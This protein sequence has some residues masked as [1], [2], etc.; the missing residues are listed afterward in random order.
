GDFAVVEYLSAEAAGSSTDVLSLDRC[1]PLTAKSAGLK[2]DSFKRDTIDVPDDLREYS[3]RPDAYTEYAK[4][5]KNLF[6]QYDAAAGKLNLMSCYSQSIKRA[7]ILADMYFK[8]TRQKI[9]LLQ[10]Q[11]EAQKQ[12]QVPGR[13][14]NTH[15]S[16]KHVEEFTVPYDLMGLAIGSHGANIQNARA[17]S[18][19]EDIQLVESDGTSPCLFKVYADSVDAAEKAR[20]LLEYSIDSCSVPRN[21]VGKVIG[22]A[23]KTIQEIVDKSGVVRVQIE[24]GDGDQRDE[25]SVDPVPF[26]F[27]GTRDAISNASFLIDFHLKHLKE[28]EEMRSNVDELNRQLYS[29]RTG[30]PPL[31]NG[32]FQARYDRGGGGYNADSGFKSGFRGGRGGPRGAF[33]GGRGGYRGNPRNG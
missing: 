29:C 9:M 5:V 28:M 18:G 12:L 4:A 32:S 26:V 20:S 6:V 22:K 8:D 17:I 30:S 2:P 7:H 13:S 1:R 27:T 10:R 14:F 33:G 3:K 31:A 24:G 25:N 19:I 11:E 23:G 21:M 16:S 15:M